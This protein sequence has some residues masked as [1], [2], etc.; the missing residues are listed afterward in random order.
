MSDS[1]ILKKKLSTYRSEKDQLR[2]VPSEIL[3][4][5][6]N[7]WEAWTGTSKDFYAAIGVSQKQMAGVI[8]KA[9]KLKRE[10]HF[11]AEE[12]QEIQLPVNPTGAG[13]GGTCI[14][15]NWNEGRVIRFSQVEQLV[16]FLKKA[17]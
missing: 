15:L 7:A 2:K 17:A 16:E 11:P 13:S 9:K 10:G 4:E 14:E 5:V 6:L 12:F 8:G 1:T 3:V